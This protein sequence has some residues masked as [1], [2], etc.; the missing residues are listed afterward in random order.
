[1]KFIIILSIYYSLNPTYFNPKAQSA[2]LAQFI[3]RYFL[4]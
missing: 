2:Q 4:T 3:S 1:M